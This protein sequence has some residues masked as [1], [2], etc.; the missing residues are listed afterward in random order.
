MPT[1][2]FDVLHFLRSKFLYIKADL[3]A[4]MFG[5][6][7]WFPWK[8]KSLNGAGCILKF[9][10]IYTFFLFFIYYYYTLVTLNH[11]YSLRKDQQLHHFHPNRHQ[12]SK[13][14]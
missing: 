4:V 13:D 9:I 11:T 5:E 10:Y 12:K 7:W 2:P 14:E 6:Q 3:K 8:K 1:Q